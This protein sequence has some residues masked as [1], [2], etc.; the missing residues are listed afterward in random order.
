MTTISLSLNET[1]WQYVADKANLINEASWNAE[2]SRKPE[3]ERISYIPETWQAYAARL[4]ASTEAS[5]MAQMI[6]DNIQ[7]LAAQRPDDIARMVKTAQLPPDTQQAI[8][9]QID[10][11]PTP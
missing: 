9:Q 4:I 7:F 8:R 5:Y 1:A 6:A 11:L 2:Q 3:G 10:A